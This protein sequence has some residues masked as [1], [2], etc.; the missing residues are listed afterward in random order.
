MIKKDGVMIPLLII[1]EEISNSKS[2]SISSV[3][4]R[5]PDYNFS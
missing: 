4:K 5:F 2:Q 1:W 3:M